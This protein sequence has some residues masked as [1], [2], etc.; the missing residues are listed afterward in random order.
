MSFLRALGVCVGGGGGLFSKG[1]VHDL[2]MQFF[3]MGS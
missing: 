2:L 1:F 3:A